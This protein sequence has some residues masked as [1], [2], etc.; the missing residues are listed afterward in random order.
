MAEGGDEQ[1]FEAECVALLR[2]IEA[3][4]KEQRRVWDEVDGFI[5]D[6]EEVAQ[7]IEVIS[8]AKHHQ[9]QGAQEKASQ[10]AKAIADSAKTAKTSSHKVKEM[11]A[12]KARVNGT[13]DLANGIAKQRSSIEGI[14]DALVKKDYERAADYIASYCE[15][16]RQLHDIA[17]LEDGDGG[18][19]LHDST[20]SEDD[21]VVEVKMSGTRATSRMMKK[22]REEVRDAVRAE[23]NA[24]ACSGD[25]DRV[26]G[27]SKLFRKLGLEEEGRMLY[28]RWL[29]LGCGSQLKQHVEKTLER[30]DAGTGESTHLRLVSDVLDHV[31]IAMESEEEHVREFFGKAGVVEMIS[32]LHQECT[33]HSVNILDSFLQANELSPLPSPAASRGPSPATLARSAAP[34]PTSPRGGPAAA[35]AKDPKGMDKTLDE[36]S[37]LSH[38]CYLYFQFIRDRAEGAPPPAADGDAARTPPP[39][40]L[41]RGTSKDLHAEAAPAAAGKPKPSLHQF[42]ASDALG[43]SDLFE[44]LQALLGCYLPLQREYL[45]AVL[46]HSITTAFKELDPQAAQAGGGGKFGDTFA[47]FQNVKIGAGFQNVLQNF[48]ID[49]GRDELL[50]LEAPLYMTD[51]IFAALR[52]TCDRVIRTKSQPLICGVCCMVN[53]LIAS[54]LYTVISERIKIRRDAPRVPKGVICWINATFLVQTY[55]KKLSDEVGHLLKKQF[56]A[57][58][59]AGEPFQV[60]LQEFASTLAVY[61]D[62]LRGALQQVSAVAAKQVHERGLVNFENLSY[63]LGE[64]KLM[65][66][67]IN[68][69]WVRAAIVQWQEVL[70]YYKDVLHQE[71]YSMLVVE[72]VG[73]TTKQMEELVMQKQFDLC[74]GLQLDRDVRAVKQY[75][76]GQTE[77]PVREKFTKLSH[78]ATLLIVDKL[79]EVEDLWSSSSSGL[80]WRLTPSEAQK[81]LLLR[82][83][84]PK[85]QVQ[86]LD[87]SKGH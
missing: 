14:G 80:M 53:E 86:A 11:D 3:L 67:E 77:N 48:G 79:S 66:Y 56:G 65:H 64:E 68:D 51:D 82:K 38:F 55:C 58:E 46:D 47:P 22:K 34:S 81:V 83:D 12:V 17:E 30:I 5:A 87:L 23:F 72:L 26:V 54:R 36:I 24:A 60:S 78:I 42:M 6:N 40:D 2:Q 7:Q 45:D 33:V 49:E 27:F 61:E 39:A 69:A 29:R 25:R 13:L 63:V 32:A 16:E 19:V 20:D 10:L 31:V 35:P 28:C 74:G 57:E 70:A 8:D 52:K 41:R 18:E 50:N 73:W 37:H 43:G 44:K 59:G 4:T 1:R 9:L 85:A 15:I 62:E 71:P 21:D 75:F 76:S 84:L